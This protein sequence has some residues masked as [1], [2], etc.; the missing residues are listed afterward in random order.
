[1]VLWPH[2]AG[3]LS[4]I[5]GQDNQRFAQ[6]RMRLLKSILALFLG[7]SAAVGAPKDT[8][9][10]KA[11]LEKLLDAALPF[12]EQMLTEHGGFYPYGATMDPEGK[13]TNVGGYTG[14][15]HPKSTEVIDLL[16]AAYRRDGEAAKI[17]ACALVCDI[18]T[19]PPGQ[20]EKTDAV[21]VDLDH[22]DGMSVVMVY[23]YRIGAD[24]K[25]QFATAFAMKG[26]GE[27]FKSK[28]KGEP[29][30]AANRSQPVGPGTN[31]TSGAAGSGR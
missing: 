16:K 5:T 30:G 19:I 21:A 18:R 10:Q 24:K 17:M 26:A 14:D 29:N 31:Q 9:T 4:D 15:E 2:C 13:I 8:K 20:T 22:R 1:M 23:P 7:A 12:A 11:E 3:M 6:M 28:A 25:V 27:I